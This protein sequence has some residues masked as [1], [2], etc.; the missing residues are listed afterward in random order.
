MTYRAVDKAGNV[1]A[2]HTGW[3]NIDL[4]APT[5]GDDAD[6]LWH[7]SAVT[8]QLSPADL[9]GSGV[10][11]TQYRLQGATDAGPRPTATPSP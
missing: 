11:A 9:G 7:N 6:A 10:A 8:V 5:V 1:E 4:V 3:V 2:P